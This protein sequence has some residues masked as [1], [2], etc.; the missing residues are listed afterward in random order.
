MA[1]S[2]K[3]RSGRQRASQPSER[4]LARVEAIKKS[5]ERWLEAAGASSSSSSSEDSDDDSTH[6]VLSKTLSKYLQD[7]GECG[8]GQQGELPV[9]LLSSA[10]GS[11]LICLSGIRRSAA[12]WSCLQCYCSYHL[13]CVQ[14]WVRDGVTDQRGAVLSPELFPARPSSWSCPK[15]RRDYP[16]SACPTEYRCYCGKQLDPPVDAWLLPHSCGELCGRTLHSGCQ[17][18]CLSLC[19]PGQSRVW[20]EEGML[21]ILTAIR[22][23]M[24]TDLCNTFSMMCVCVCCRSLS[25]VP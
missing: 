1:W 5:G 10:P 21:M 14:L 2:G 11:C 23:A 24:C 6:H 9:S 13:E 16:Q 22:I 25:P 7:F 17:H 15:C 8:G 12:V 19:H 4:T 3:K 20:C 18:R